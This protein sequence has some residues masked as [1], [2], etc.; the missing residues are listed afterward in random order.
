MMSEIE[1]FSVDYSPTHRAEMD[2]K[3]GAGWHKR[4]I[5]QRAWIKPYFKVFQLS[6]GR[7]AKVTSLEIRSNVTVYAN[8]DEFYKAQDEDNRMMPDPETGR[9]PALYDR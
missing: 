4:L 6:D 8:R 9:R 2:A 1:S 7:V 5:T 3:L